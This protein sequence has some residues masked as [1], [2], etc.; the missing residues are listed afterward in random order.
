[1]RGGPVTFR[2]QEAAQGA[3]REPGFTAW[4]S[5]GVTLG[6]SCVTLG[7]SLHVGSQG[8]VCLI[9]TTSAFGG[10][11]LCGPQTESSEVEQS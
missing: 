10:L 11:G 7:P 8:S 1:M 3:R 5:W 4:L 6:E 2:L 9:P